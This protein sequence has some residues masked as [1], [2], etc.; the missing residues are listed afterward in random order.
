MATKLTSKI[1]P[2]TITVDG[3]PD[4]LTTQGLLRVEIIAFPPFSEDA[5]V[6]YAWFQDGFMAL[7]G[8]DTFP[9]VN[10]G[11]EFSLMTQRGAVDERG[12]ASGATMLLRLHTPNKQTAPQSAVP[13]IADALEHEKKVKPTKQPP[14]AAIKAS[15]P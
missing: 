6:Q 5:D 1:G 14:T 8:S 7:G 2:L 10:A 9:N 11:D 3:L 12:A 15:K 13:A 4:G